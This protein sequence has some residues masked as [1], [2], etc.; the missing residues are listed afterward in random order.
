MLTI[1]FFTA[2]FGTRA[3]RFYVDGSLPAK[4][5]VWIPADGA[6]RRYRDQERLLAYRTT[7]GST[8][9]NVIRA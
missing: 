1:G 2:G 7:A 4:V 5:Q 8:N 9:Y 6:T 3:E